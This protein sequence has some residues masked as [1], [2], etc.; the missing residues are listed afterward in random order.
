M[1]RKTQSQV[2]M[3]IGSG[4]AQHGEGCRRGVVEN[5]QRESECGD[6]YVLNNHRQSS[7]VNL[8]PEFAFHWTCICVHATCPQFCL[9][10]LSCSRRAYSIWQKRGN[11]EGGPNGGRFGLNWPVL[12]SMG[13]TEFMHGRFESPGPRISTLVWRRSARSPD[14]SLT[15][16]QLEITV[17]ARK[18]LI[19]VC[20][21]TVSVIEREGL[22]ILRRKWQASRS[23]ASG[24]DLA[25]YHQ[26]TRSLDR[27]TEEAFG[28]GLGEMNLCIPV[29]E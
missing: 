25:A 27:C 9:I 22:M 1:N 17:T 19:G 16:L 21:V 23:V 28:A 12:S 2:E 14:G 7:L 18:T 3:A 29:K 24:F 15:V 20:R 5:E 8:G 4:L 13:A 6:A 10:G 26:C 11:R